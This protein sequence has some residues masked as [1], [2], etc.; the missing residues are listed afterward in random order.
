MTYEEMYV[1]PDEYAAA[2]ARGISKRRVQTR[3]YE[4]WKKADALTRPVR[5]QVDRTYWRK[6]AEANGI[7]RQLFYKRVKALGW[8][9]ERAAT[10]PIQDS[11]MALIECN[12]RKRTISEAEL[13][14]AAENGIPKSVIHWRLK[15]GWS[16][17]D[18]CAR[19]V[20]TGTERGKSSRAK[21]TSRY[22]D[23]MAPLF[24]KRKKV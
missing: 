16:R 23:L 24:E 21:L 5:Q 8:S 2:E 9:E 4:G 15:H 7:G 14:Q 18:A 1:T 12:K 17:E 11:L 22:G 6:I 10:D 13:E 19:K 20:M 3:M